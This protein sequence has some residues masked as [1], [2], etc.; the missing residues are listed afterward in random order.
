MFVETG[1]LT[2]RSDPKQ[3]AVEQVERYRALVEF[4]LLR[5]SR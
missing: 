5:R 4:I 3:D 2:L 1:I